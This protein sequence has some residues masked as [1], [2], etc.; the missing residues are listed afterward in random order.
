MD[1][2][3]TNEQKIIS[4]FSKLSK[5]GKLKWLA[6]NFFK[7]PQ[8]T[9]EELRSYWH[10]DD[11]QQKILDGFS[12]NTISNFPM[13]FGVAPNFLIDGKPYA[14]PMVI[15]E[16]SVVA[17]ASMAA[18]Y[19]MSRGGFKTTILGTIKI[20]QVHFKWFGG[21]ELFIK[22]FPQIKADLIQ[23]AKS[24][25]ANMDKRGGGILDIELLDFTEKEDGLYQLRC[26]FETCDSMG[27]N[28]IN[29]VLEQFGKS[30]QTFIFNHPST[31]A[32][33]N[34]LMVIMCILSNFTPDCL[35]RA[36]VSCPISELGTM[37]F[38]L[39]AEALAYK[40]W[41]AIRIAEIDPYRATTHNKGI[42]NG[43]DAVVLATGNDF[44]AIEACGHAYAAKDGQ[45]KSLS[46]CSIEDD[47]FRFWID[48]PLAVG[49]V[50]G[51]TNLHPIAKKSL[52]L[53]GNPT[54]EELMKVIAVTGLAQNFAAIRSLITTG[55][56]S[57]HMKM[58][59][60]NILHQLKA[61]D[62]EIENAVEYFSDKVVSFSAVRDFLEA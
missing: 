30:L 48:M 6:E 4:G 38:D 13:P 56:Q 14:V 46:H 32:Q 39:D 34:Q 10:S 59:L 9:I 49:T 5:V 7:D 11:D 62:N 54:A 45:Y 25:T 31:S 57:G 27:A 58:H 60:V 2:K 26:S 12:E 52:E 55:I 37:G 24:I 17:A 42:F 15:E 53:L 16:S 29:S 3:T 19:W 35:V 51:L 23:E 21:K 40:F 41:T 1:H 28:F 50:G 33:S 47:V 20:G 8:S 61:R 36:E 44:R 18:K 22:I 43:I